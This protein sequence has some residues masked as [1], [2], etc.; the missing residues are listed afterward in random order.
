MSLKM[1]FL[2]DFARADDQ[3]HITIWNIKINFVPLKKKKIIKRIQCVKYRERAF[4]GFYSGAIF[5][6]SK[7]QMSAGICPVVE[8][9]A[10]WKFLVCTCRSESPV[11]KAHKFRWMIFRHFIISN[12]VKSIPETFFVNI[13]KVAFIMIVINI[14]SNQFCVNLEWHIALLSL[15]FCFAR[16]SLTT[17]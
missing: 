10:Q 14:V 9:W 16:G 15:H 3:S 1:L 7:V 13:L 17:L 11:Q 6:E 5:R 8:A 2:K 12:F 4:N